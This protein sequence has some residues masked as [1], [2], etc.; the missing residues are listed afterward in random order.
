MRPISLNPP[1]AVCPFAVIV[2]NQ[3]QLPWRFTGIEAEDKSPLTVPLITDRHLDA[4]DYSIDG[5]ESLVRI[6]RKSV[7][8]FYGSIGGGHERE[9]RKAERLSHFQYAAYVIEG[10]WPD[11]LNYSFKTQIPA[12]AARGTIAAWAIRYRLGFWLLPT[13]RDAEVWCF[14]LLEMFYRQEIHNRKQLAKAL[15]S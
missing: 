9:E 3:E 7:A 10:D 1:L 2:D 15:E 5:M 8:D 6:E 13:R 4:G 11:V 14:R 12:A